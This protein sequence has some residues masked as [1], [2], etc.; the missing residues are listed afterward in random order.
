[1]ERFPLHLENI[2][3]LPP[4]LQPHLLL[5]AETAKK[6]PLPTH[7]DVKQGLL[8]LHG[9]WEGQSEVQVKRGNGV[10]WPLMQVSR[11]ALS[12]FRWQFLSGF[13]QDIFQLR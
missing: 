1:M 12:H 4:T 3:T 9:I 7:T 13:H 11:G 10:F 5:L 6:N 8:P 2:S